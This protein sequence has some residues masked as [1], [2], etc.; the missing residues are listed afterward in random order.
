VFNIVSYL[1]QVILYALRDIAYSWHIFLFDVVSNS[2]SVVW[3]LIIY[4]WT[5]FRQC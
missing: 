4:F 2:F 5:I 1:C 3:S